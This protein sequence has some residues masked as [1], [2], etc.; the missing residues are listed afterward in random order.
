MVLN[1]SPWPV[2]SQFALWSALSVKIA[3]THSLNKRSMFRC[4][5][6]LAQYIENASKFTLPEERRL[7]VQPWKD[8]TTQD[9]IGIRLDLNRF[10][11]GEGIPAHFLLMGQ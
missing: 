9:A 8:A 10:A 7:E 5:Q 6:P 2:K 3:R 1:R 11:I 4:C